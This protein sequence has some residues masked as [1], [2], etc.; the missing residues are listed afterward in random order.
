[1]GKLSLDWKIFIIYPVYK[2][3]RNR[4]KPGNYKGILLVL[5]CGKIFLGILAGRLRD[6][7]IYQKA[8]KY[9]K[10]GFLRQTNHA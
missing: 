8:H 9:S 6:W 4:E 3:K 5:A 1:M 10:W 2:V 7:L